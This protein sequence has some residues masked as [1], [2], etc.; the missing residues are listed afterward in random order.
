MQR[1]LR[2]LW[3][4]GRRE[5]CTGEAGTVTPADGCWGQG[6]CW[7]LGRA[8]PQALHFKVATWGSGPTRHH[9]PC[10]LQA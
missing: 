2:S 8:F 1:V 6:G 10:L 9:P 4:S 3:C 5:T 7:H